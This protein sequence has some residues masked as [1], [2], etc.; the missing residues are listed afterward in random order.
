MK[1]EIYKKAEGLLGVQ[2]RWQLVAAN[3]RTIG[4]GE[5]YNNKEDCLHA[6]GLLM[7]CNRQTPVYE[8]NA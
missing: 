5:G 6:V 2:W 3:G 7:D 1:F 8:V 4:S